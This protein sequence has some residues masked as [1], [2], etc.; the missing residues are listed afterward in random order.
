MTSIIALLSITGT[1]IYFFWKRR[2]NN[3]L[4]T[5]DYSFGV[6][7]AKNARDLLK[8]EKYDE[9]EKL[10]LSLK[11][12]I[13]TLTIDY[14]TLTNETPVFST[15]L[16]KSKSKDVAKLCLGVHYLHKAWISRSHAA[17]DDVSE[18]K[19]NEF[20]EYQELSLEQLSSIHDNLKLY[21]EIN[22]RSIRLAMGMENYD[23]IPE[24]FVNAISKDN[25][26]LWPYLHY[27][28]AI[29][30]K[31]GG[32]LEMIS[33]LLKNLPKISIIQYVVELKLVLDSLKMDEN[34]FGGTMEE[35]NKKAKT[36]ITKIDTEI[37]LRPI[38]SINK[39]IVYGYIYLIANY[40][41]NKELEKKYVELLNGNYTLYPFGI[42]KD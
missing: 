8:Q 42:Q 10:I 31:W 30:P 33:D 4:P 38:N 13:L 15:W 17:G 35:L 28:E 12:E 29:E 9:L 39:Y 2:K 32:E 11:P 7:E 25:S 37:E 21:E 20:F 27:C 18:E 36:L 3:G 34:Y 14:L 26:M 23:L 41:E 24:Y 19:A 16:E 22:S 1:I 40:I 6:S 5:V